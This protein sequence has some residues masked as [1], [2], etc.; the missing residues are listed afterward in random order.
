MVPVVA[1]G[2][3]VIHREDNLFSARSMGSFYRHDFLYSLLDM[4]CEY[5]RGNKRT[6]EN[7]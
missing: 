5:D 6:I 2:L 4:K 7:Q 3:S 1:K